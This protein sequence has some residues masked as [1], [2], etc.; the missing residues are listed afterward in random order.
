MPTATAAIVPAN[1]PFSPV[2]TRAIIEQY[3]R[4]GYALIPGVLTPAEVAAAHEA[5]ERAFAD[6]RMA[7]THNLYDPIVMTRLFELDPL[8]VKF[9]T[10][11]PIISL[12]EALLGPDCHLIANNTVRNP[13]GKAIDSFHADDFLWFPLPESIPRHDARITMPN[14]LVNCH[15]ALTD[16]PSD[17]YGPLQ[18]VPGSHYSGRQP[19]DAKNPTFEGRGPVSVHAKAG[20]CY[21]QHPQVWHRGAPNTS[22]R[23]R[24]IF[25]MAWAKRFVAQRFYPFLNYT[26]PPAVL[27][28]ADERLL[29]VLG[30]HAKGAYG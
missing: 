21:L 9:L 18:V 26:V 23:T 3:N 24:C 4:D 28:G 11:E 19:N 29:R 10:R 22:N 5:I 1:Q 13:P 20:D 30:K 17:E 12:M 16:V 14:F 15:H 7:E 8:F 6:P 2:K 25:G 27:E